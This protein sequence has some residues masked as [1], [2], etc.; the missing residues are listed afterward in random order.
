M[1][2]R[3]FLLGGFVLILLINVFIFPNFGRLFGAENTMQYILDVRFCYSV[4]QAYSALNAMGEAG[5]KAYFWT[6]LLVDMPYLIIYSLTYTL[7]LFLLINRLHIQGKKY[8][9]YLPFVVGL[10]DFFENIGILLLLTTYPEKHTVLAIIT[11]LFTSLK[12]VSAAIVF[13]LL[14]LLLFRLILRKIKNRNHSSHSDSS[15]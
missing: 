4:D 6:V 14:L 8:W 3:S 9:G 7:L 2:K 13:L 15:V 5:R 11:A 1:N 10:F 12:W